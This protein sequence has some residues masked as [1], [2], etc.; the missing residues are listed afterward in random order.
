MTPHLRLLLSATYPRPSIRRVG[1]RYA[2]TWSTGAA[3]APLS[4]HQRLLSAWL[5]VGP[6][7]PFPRG[8]IG[9]YVSR[10]APPEKG[11]RDRAAMALG[12]QGLCWFAQYSRAPMLVTVDMHI[13]RL[14]V[15]ETVTT[16]QA[17]TQR[18]FYGAPEVAVSQAW[19]WVKREYGC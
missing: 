6:L 14:L 4:A 19:A 17:A 7:R 8:R 16:A 15:T 11:L 10:R 12:N 18:E 2:V 3:L 1:L 13:G 9:F 5:D